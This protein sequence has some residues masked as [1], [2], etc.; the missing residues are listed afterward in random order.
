MAK[1]EEFSLLVTVYHDGKEK[2][3]LPIPSSR[4]LLAWNF[5]ISTKKWGYLHYLLWKQTQPL[6]DFGIPY[7]IKCTE[8]RK[9]HKEGMESESESETTTTKENNPSSLSVGATDEDVNLDIVEV[10][11]VFHDRKNFYKEYK[12][13]VAGMRERMQENER[14]R[15][16]QKAK[17]VLKN[18]PP[19][20]TSKYTTEEIANAIVKHYGSSLSH[21]IPKAA[22]KKVAE[23]IVV[24]GILNSA[25]EPSAS[26]SSPS[27]VFD[28]LEPIMELSNKEFEK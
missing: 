3:V 11:K 21:S 15:I 17:N 12:L 23:H 10:V 26:L 14:K 9:S 1:N 16:E 22:L 20:L 28:P 24:S 5:P 18:K 27:D 6:A 13:N 19:L 8:I 4:V 2:R 25:L 7:R